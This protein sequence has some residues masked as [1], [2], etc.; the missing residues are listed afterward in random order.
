MGASPSGTQVDK[1]KAYAGITG[2]GDD[3][4]L[5]DIL[6]SA[7]H[8]VGD[9][10]GKS[11]LQYGAQVQMDEREGL[12]VVPLYGT[13]AGINSVK[14]G[15]GND[16]PYVRKGNFIYPKVKAE[17]VVVGYNCTPTAQDVAS[18]WGKCVRYATALYDNRDAAE[19][20]KILTSRC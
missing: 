5:A 16:I 4:L 17:V 10:E 14:D 12:E 9:W 13:I 11:L 8:A 18:L 6:A 3:D 20:N 2:R 19:L 7:M 1:L 15:R